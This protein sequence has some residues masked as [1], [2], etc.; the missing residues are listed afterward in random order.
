MAKGKGLLQT[1]WAKNIMN[2][3][4]GVAAAIVILGALFKILHWKGAT[5][6]LMVGMLLS[7][8][9]NRREAWVPAPGNTSLML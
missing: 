7:G 9:I 6:M 1:K 5:E 8:W 4:Y 3:I 2:I